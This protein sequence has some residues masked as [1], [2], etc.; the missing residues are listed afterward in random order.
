[1]DSP[2]TRKV[3][4]TDEGRGTRKRPAE[5]S[6]AGTGAGSL[7]S[8]GLERLHRDPTAE[9]LDLTGQAAGM[10]L[11]KALGE[12]VGAEVLVGDASIEVA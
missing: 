2:L 11:G 3:L 9:R 5:D 7:G 12:P 8:G 10:R 6:R 1:M 4:T